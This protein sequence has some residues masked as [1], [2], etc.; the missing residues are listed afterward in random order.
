MTLR[1]CSSQNWLG[2]ILKGRGFYSNKKLCIVYSEYIKLGL[3][4]MTRILFWKAID[5]DLRP[6][7]LI[8]S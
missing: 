5:I 2:A 1:H 3:K 7:T 4:A 6:S 8:E